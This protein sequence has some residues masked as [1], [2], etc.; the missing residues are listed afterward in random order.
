MCGAQL[1]WHEGP[2]HLHGEPHELGVTWMAT[3]CMRLPIWGLLSFAGASLPSTQLAA[4]HACVQDAGEGGALLLATT[5]ERARAGTAWNVPSN[6]LAID[7]LVHAIPITEV[8]AARPPHPLS[9]RLHGWHAYRRSPLPRVCSVLR[10][11]RAARA[12]WTPPC[13]LAQLLNP[14]GIALPPHATSRF[15]HSCCARITN[16]ASVG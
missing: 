5:T 16:P 2:G 11:A 9:P 1:C 14:K 3:S 13:S 7:T 6:Q 4:P 8:A 15:D 12:M 10:T